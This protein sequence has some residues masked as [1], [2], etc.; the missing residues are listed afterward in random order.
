MKQSAGS[1]EDI[2][3][4][5]QTLREVAKSEDASHAAK[6]AAARTILEYYGYLGTGRSQVPDLADKSHAELSL[7]ELKRRAADLRRNAPSAPSGPAP[8]DPLT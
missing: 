7:T 1:H 8:F 4:A 2:T 5:L 3:L 6:Q